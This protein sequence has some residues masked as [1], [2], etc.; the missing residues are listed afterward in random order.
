MFRIMLLGAHLG[1][2]FRGSGSQPFL[3][4]DRTVPPI[5][6]SK[7]RQNLN[8]IWINIIHPFP[9]HFLVTSFINSEAVKVVMLVFCSIHQ[10][11]LETFLPILVSLNRPSLQILVKT[12][13]VCMS[14]FW[15]SGQSFINKNCHHSRASHD[16][17]MKL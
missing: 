15:T 2:G 14:N 9:T 12:Q 17:D 3:Q 10:F 11:L 6:S 8:L 5:L 13:T 4:I 7:S 16:I 1:Q